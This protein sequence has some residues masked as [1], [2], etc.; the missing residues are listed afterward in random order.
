MTTI[1]RCVL[2]N[3]DE[4]LY[5]IQHDGYDSSLGFDVCL[6]R[7]ERIRDELE[8]RGQGT[9]LGSGA[10]VARGD[11]RTYDTYMIL[12]DLLHNEVDLSGEPAVCELSPQLNG[13]EGHRVVVVSRDGGTREFIV[14]RAGIWLP[15]HMEVT[16]TGTR[17]VRAEHE[18]ASVLDLGEAW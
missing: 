15:H 13:L 2:V 5:V 7:I 3:H 16:R 14:G 11:I 6:E 1:E 17:G 12:L 10:Q 8:M 4:E 9:M 18:Y